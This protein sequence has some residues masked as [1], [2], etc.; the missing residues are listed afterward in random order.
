MSQQERKSLFSQPM[1]RV[2]LCCTAC[3]MLTIGGIA[4]ANFIRNKSTVSATSLSEAELGEIVAN[5]VSLNEQERYAAAVELLI[6]VCRTLFERKH[7][8]GLKVYAESQAM[9]PLEDNAHIKL[10]ASTLV[11]I[12]ALDANDLK[13]R[14]RLFQLYRQLGEHAEAC[15][16]GDEAVAL[17]TDDAGLCL[18]V[19]T[20]HLDAD[21]PAV[22]RQMA[23]SILHN[24]AY[25]LQA[26]S[27]VV[28][29]MV[30]QEVDADAIVA[31]IDSD[32][33]SHGESTQLDRTLLSL[34]LANAANDGEGRTLLTSVLANNTTTAPLD[35][36]RTKMLTSA[37]ES[38]ART[39]AA[40]EVAARS[41][42]PRSVLTD[43]AGQVSQLELLHRYLWAGEHQRLQ[44]CI[45]EFRTDNANMA[46]E[47]LVIRFMSCWL[48]GQRAELPALAKQHAER[49]SHRA[50]CWQ[51]VVASLAAEQTASTEMLSVVV[52]ALQHYPQSPVLQFLHAVSLQSL[53]DND[54]A[55]PAYRLAIGLSPRW[56]TPRI[57]LSRLYLDRG[58]HRLA[59]GESVEAVRANP[60]SDVALNALVLSAAKMHA[61]GEEL[62]K[63]VRQAVLKTI[64]QG[65]D[66]ATN[67]RSKALLLATYHA[68]NHEQNAAHRLIEMA[69][70]NPDGLSG[71][72]FELLETIALSSD[73]KQEINVRRAATVG[74]S[75]NELLAET[76]R[77]LA[78]Q[79][80]PAARDYLRHPQRNAGAP[81][82]EVTQELLLAEALSAVGSSE[83]MSAWRR[84]AERF[85]NDLQVQVRAA[86]A[87]EFAADFEF[88]KGITQRIQALS[89]ADGIIWRIEDTRLLLDL[90]TS[91]QA[92]A[93]AALTMTDVL[94]TAPSTAAA[95]GLAVR[96][97]DRLQKTEPVLE[98][99]RKAVAHGVVIPS[100]TVRLA[101]STNLRE[102]A[103]RIAQGIVRGRAFSEVQRKKAIAVLLQH[104]AYGL[105]AE[106]I[107]DDLSD[108]V[109]D[110]DDDFALF[111]TLAIARANHGS[112]DLLP[113]GIERL[114]PKSDRWFQL[115]LDISQVMN[116][117]PKQAAAML[118]QAADWMKIDQPD[119]HR[120]LSIAWRRLAK[121][122]QNSDYLKPAYQV[123]KSVVN[124]NSSAQNQMILAG[125]ALKV[126]DR[127]AAME[128]YQW[129]SDQHADDSQVCSIALNNLASLKLQDPQEL[130]SA[131]ALAVRAYAMQQQPE[132]IDT[133]IEVRL[134][135]DRRS[136]A[137]KLLNEGLHKWPQNLH[138][139]RLATQMSSEGDRT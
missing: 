50:K 67:E 53:G 33:L 21:E 10:A 23:E 119:R 136:E 118:E 109:E 72:D 1:A 110:S 100:L 82:A 28:Q 47:V 14:L 108:I 92:A 77:R 123:L 46:D 114:A 13:V 31:F 117:P 90:D 93:R 89:P 20:A 59:F 104:Q 105:A 25:H 49:N 11:R 125:L 6:P 70:Q 84:L 83:A 48:N 79:G 40:L 24:E 7:I 37:F 103:I 98:L 111:S 133:L 60:Q 45:S 38:A 107:T 94:S 64:Q 91:E 41:M 74:P 36:V 27:L 15:R 99:C 87:R 76:A 139:K 61:S 39:Q 4:G 134:R 126:D 80:V 81:L 78:D 5:A 65:H 26:A 131:D 130:H 19:A 97:Y 121:R 102:E 30:A 17:A 113:A 12:A 55:V 35:V 34:T 29:C 56:N 22:A 106:A 115:W 42:S 96:A 101:E 86:N 32:C 66:R 71:T 122:S 73:L 16:Y 127:A 43:Q 62:G 58:N 137:M 75:L 54:A 18:R 112:L 135:Q 138:L 44:Q 3:A 116:V 124:A 8:V 2:A 63:D 95:Y 128:A 9:V 51:P 88:R 129:V 69:L 120:S 85:D 132:I 57:A 52:T 68:L